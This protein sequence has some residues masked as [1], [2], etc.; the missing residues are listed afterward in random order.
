MLPL[1][2]LRHAFARSVAV[3]CFLTLGSVAYAEDCR[4]MIDDLNAAVDSGDE[5]A[6]QREI[7]KISVSAECGSYQAA[8]QRRLA[9]QRL[10]TVE[11]LMA[12]GRPIEDFNRL[13]VEAETPQVL[14]QASATLGEVRFGARQFA[15]AAGAFDRAIEIVKNENLTPAAPSKSEI[16][17]LFE[18]AAQ[19]RL[20]AANDPKIPSDQKFVKTA[21]DQRDGSLGGLYS[22]SVRG[23]VPH[24]IPVP[25]T[26]VYRKTD[27]TDA[28]NEAAGEL[29]TAIKEQNPTRVVL[30]GH[31][32]SRGSARI[33]MKLSI[34]RAEAVAAF[35]QQNGV[36]IPIAAIG[37]GANEPLH[38]SDPSGLS[39]EDIYAL[40][41]RVEW[42]RD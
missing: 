29:L 30:V 1:I 4:H 42:L 12:R 10:A 9:A 28:G 14:W 6:A 31:T 8:A 39:Q 19:A 17:K 25:I 23:I 27:F 33:N 13:L 15:E 38:L 36:N 5:T 21:R 7:D 24:A 20:L 22:S 18:R 34:A 35:L 11:A 2:T 3:S 40:N 37:K 32:D 26:F 16:Y 41:R